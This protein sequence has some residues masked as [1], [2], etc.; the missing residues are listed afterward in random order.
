MHVTVTNLAAEGGD[1]AETLRR[2][3][4]GS[5]FDMIVMGAFVHSW[6]RQM[7]LGGVT[8]SLLDA[9]PVPLCSCPIEALEPYRPG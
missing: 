3:R 7:V 2:H 1:V 6:M 8:R 5:A 4:R 9:S